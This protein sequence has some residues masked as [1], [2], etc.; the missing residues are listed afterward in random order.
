MNRIGIIGGETHIAEITKLAGTKIEIVGAAV[1]ADQAESVGKE[2]GCPVVSDYNELFDTYRPEIVGI[3]NENNL[4]AQAILDSLDRGCDVIVDKPLAIS[5]EEQRAIERKLSEK[6]ERKLLNL[7]TLRAMGHWRALRDRVTAG[8]LGKPAFMHVRMAVRLKRDQRPPWFLDVRYAGGPILDLLIHGI[9]QVEW[10]TESRITAITAVMGN[11][12][13]PSDE[14]L[15]DHAAVFCEL[16]SGASA[17][18]EG[19]RML[20]DTKGSDYRVH[21]AGTFG[22]AD[23]DHV[24][25]ELYITTPEEAEKRIDSLPPDL[26]LVEQWLDGGDLVTQEESLRANRLSVLATRSADARQRMTVD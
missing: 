2:L 6:P 25:K 22:Y 13:D 10:I 1:R 14:H 19:Q 12:S 8:V 5:A 17:V 24:D 4:K 16:A 15:R 20:P 26:S 7:L 3:A 9:D 23:L 18:V 21:L 11:L